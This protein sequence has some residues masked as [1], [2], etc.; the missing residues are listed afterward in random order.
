MSDETHTHTPTVTDNRA[1]AHTNGDRLQKT[2]KYRT[3]V[4]PKVGFENDFNPPTSLNTTKLKEQSRGNS[5]T[6]STSGRKHK[7]QLPS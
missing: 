7:N 5:T 6:L 4:F 2:W 3:I 1:H